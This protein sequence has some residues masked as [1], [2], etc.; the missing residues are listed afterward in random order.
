LPCSYALKQHPELLCIS[1]TGVVEVADILWFL[2]AI[3]ED[4]GYRQGMYENV[5][6]SKVETMR[7]SPNDV[8]RLAQLALGLYTRRKPFD[9]CAIWAPAEEIF[10]TANRYCTVLTR[11]RRLNI[12]TFHSEEAALSYLYPSPDQER[13]SLS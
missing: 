10:G 4:P 8:V 6:L 11:F 5:D 12:Q 7:I 3:E 1:F 2:D 13:V 9:R